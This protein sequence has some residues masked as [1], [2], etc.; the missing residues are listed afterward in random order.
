MSPTKR[1]Q[2]PQTPTKV[3]NTE[4][5]E[6]PPP[7]TQ[8][9]MGDWTV[10]KLKKELRY[11]NLSPIGKKNELLNRLAIDDV[12]NSKII[13]SSEN[14][15]F[16]KKVISEK[17]SKVAPKRF[18]ISIIFAVMLSLTLSI[19]LYHNYYYRN[20]KFGINEIKVFLLNVDTKIA[21]FASFIFSFALSLLI[22][23]LML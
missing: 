23:Y 4:C 21:L 7:G 8:Y 13:A 19:A 17:K 10:T 1:N 3:S 22:R 16:N 2:T 5:Q 15:L 6:S 14:N 18:I 20:G 9:K 11:R 12:G